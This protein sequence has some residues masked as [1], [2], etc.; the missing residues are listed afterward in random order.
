MNQSPFFQCLFKWKKATALVNTWR[1][2][3][4]E[5]E[6]VCIR[7]V[8]GQTQSQYLEEKKTGMLT[9]PLLCW[10]IMPT[11]TLI[12]YSI[13]LCLLSEYKATTSIKIGEKE[14]G[15]EREIE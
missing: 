13:I 4:G 14:S 12:I 7:M 3:V 9:H 10:V 5:K 2:R 6:I 1:E 15:I 8:S 11:I